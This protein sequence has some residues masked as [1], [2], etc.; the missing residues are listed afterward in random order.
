MALQA[1]LLFCVYNVTRHYECFNDFRYKLDYTQGFFF[2]FF[3]CS[4]LRAPSGYVR[5]K[6][7]V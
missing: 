4:W 2:F 1:F 6:F 5:N 3:K 7:S